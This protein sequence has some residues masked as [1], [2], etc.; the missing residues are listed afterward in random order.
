MPR[1]DNQAMRYINSIVNWRTVSVVLALAAC[2]AQTA[3]AGLNRIESEDWGKTNDGLT[4]QRVTLCNSKGMTVRVMSLGAAITELQ[5]PDK[6]GMAASVVN[7][8]TTWSAYQ[9]GFALAALVHG[10]VANRIGGAKFT[11]DGKDYVLTPNEN[12][13]GGQNLLHGGKKGW[14]TQVWQCQPQPPKEHESSVVFTYFSKD[15][16]EGFPGNV[17]AKVTYTLNDDNE[18]SITYEATTDKPTPINMTNHA[19]F[20]LAG[21]TGTNSIAEQEL[22]IDADKYLVASAQLVP[23]GEMK[24]VKGTPYDF[25]TPIKIGARFDQL[26]ASRGVKTYDN[27]FVLNHSGDG[28][29]AVAARASDAASGRVM[30]V[31]TDQPGI[32]LYTGSAQHPGFCLETQHHPDSVN[33][34]EFPSTILKPGDTFK[35]TTVFAFSLLK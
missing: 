7:G 15:G 20:N 31:R 23:T 17:T 27:A 9:R 13:P 32:Q 24:A 19:Y 8:S 10:R 25:T 21:A 11:M 29:T 14:G 12:L 1:A 28:K 26:A 33:R 30:E 3:P 18:F 2:V 16:E 22:W 34:P 4:V 5:V 6:S 35:T